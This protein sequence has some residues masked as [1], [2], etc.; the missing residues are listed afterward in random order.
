[1]SLTIPPP[2]EIRCCAA[3][4]YYCTIQGVKRF[5]R[6]SRRGRYKLKDGTRYCGQHYGKLLREGKV[7]PKEALNICP[8]CNRPL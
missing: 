5:H 4:E 1:M 2:D 3:T 6:C 8:V 7:D